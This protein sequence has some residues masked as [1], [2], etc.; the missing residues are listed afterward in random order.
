MSRLISIMAVLVILC[1]CGAVAESADEAIRVA[2]ADEAASIMDEM[3]KEFQASHPGSFVIVTASDTVS[4]Y[5]ALINKEIEVAMTGSDPSEKLKEEAKKAGVTMEPY[6]MGYTAQVVFVRKDLPVDSLNLEQLAKIYT[7]ELKNWSQVG[8]P[9]IQIALNELNHERHSDVK[10]FEETVLKGAK[11][12]PDID[13]RNTVRLLMFHAVEEPGSI[14]YCSLGMYN[15]IMRARPNL[16]LKL[17]K[18][19]RDTV[20]EPVAPIETAILSGLYPMLEP[21]SVV[22]DSASASPLVKKFVELS[23]DT[24]RSRQA[25]ALAREGTRAVSSGTGINDTTSR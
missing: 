12:S 14:G 9:N 22:I 3:G 17:L 19:A 11:P 18:I 25:A 10:W 24:I 1:A 13:E 23:R 8:G 6:P 4:G 5:E 21:F 16:N 15:S 2:G 20:S 7:G